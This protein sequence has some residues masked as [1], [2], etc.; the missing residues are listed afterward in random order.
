MVSELVAP[1]GVVPDVT[2]DFRQTQP[3]GKQV[4]RSAFQLLQTIRRHGPHRHPRKG[5]FDVVV[6]D[7]AGDLFDHV[8]FDLDVACGPEAGRLDGHGGTV[9]GNRELERRQNLG[10]PLTRDGMAHEAAHELRI[11]GD[12]R[13][14]QRLGKRVAQAAG[15]LEIL[16][17]RPG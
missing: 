4:Q 6:A 3:Q 15:Q 8:R 14:G 9:V 16:E 1:F 17:L 5:G 10:D 12:R 11:D 2:V 7:V 13:F